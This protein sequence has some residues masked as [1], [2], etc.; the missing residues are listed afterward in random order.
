MIEPILIELKLKR[1]EQLKIFSDFKKMYLRT[2]S[3]LK[4]KFPEVETDSIHVLAKMQ[5]KIEAE[6]KND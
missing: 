5:L 3:D 4:D 6:V 1:H 2:E